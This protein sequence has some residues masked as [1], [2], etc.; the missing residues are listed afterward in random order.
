MLI[1]SDGT[2]FCVEGFMGVDFEHELALDG[3]RQE[4]IHASSRDCILLGNQ[5]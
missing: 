1:G 2:W 5:I 4:F 3:I